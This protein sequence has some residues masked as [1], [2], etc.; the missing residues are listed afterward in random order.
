MPN[1]WRR[2]SN[3][4]VGRGLVKISASCSV[5]G[6][7]SNLTTLSRTCS[8]RKW[9]LIGICFV[10][11]CITGFFE[12]LIALVLSQNMGIDSSYVTYMSC[13]FCF[14]QRTWVQHAAAATYSASAVERVIEDCF[15]LN[16]ETKQPPKKNVAPLVLL[17]VSTHP[18]Q[19]ASEKATKSNW[20]PLG[21]HKPNSFMP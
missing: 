15:L 12:I 19:S 20:F 9:N 8:L 16:H 4:V 13:R 5:V 3:V 14:I 18:T 2:Y 11:E 7:Y 10:L 1:C 17:H 6:T 21:Y